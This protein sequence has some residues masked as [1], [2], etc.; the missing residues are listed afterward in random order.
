M[1]EA[2][3]RYRTKAQESTVDRHST[4]IENLKRIEWLWDTIPAGL[5]ISSAGESSSCYLSP[6]LIKPVTAE[7]HYASRFPSAIVDKAM[8]DDILI[9]RIDEN[10]IHYE[11]FSG[12]IFEQ[13]VHAFS[14]YKASIIL[15]PQIVIE[16]REEIVVAVQETGR[17]VN[18][19]DGVFRFHAVNFF[20]DELC[21]RAFNL[22]PV[23]VEKRLGGHI[24]RV[25]VQDNGVLIIAT[26]GLV[27]HENLD[28]INDHITTLIQSS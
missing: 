22:T 11:K 9:M 7:I 27:D 19:R 28:A 2:V 21:R 14:A 5:P 1:I 23:E 8:S 10:A 3:F 4:V 15:D 24:Q 13:I 26:T 6:Y 17:D 20:D 18:G 12:I 16:D 25:S